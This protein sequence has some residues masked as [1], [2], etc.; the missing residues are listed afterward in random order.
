MGGYVFKNFGIAAKILGAVIF[1][2][3]A[4]DEAYVSEHEG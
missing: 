2:F 1:P 4:D 3:C